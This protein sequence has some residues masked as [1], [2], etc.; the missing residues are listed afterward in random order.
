M[1]SR[2]K[3]TTAP[4]ERA[5][6]GRWRRRSRVAALALGA[7]GALAKPSIDELN[8]RIAG[9]RDQAQALGAQI[10]AH[11]GRARGRPAAGDRRR[12]AR[13]AAHRG[14][15]GRASTR[16]A[17]RG[18]G[19][20]R[21]AGRS[22][23]LASSSAARSTRSPT[24]WWRSTAAG[25]P[26]RP[27]SC[28]TPTASTT[29]RPAPSTCAGSR[30]PTRRS[31]AASAALRDQVSAQARRG[32]RAPR[33]APRPPTTRSRPPATRSPPSAPTPRPRRPQL[34]GLRAQR[35]AAVDSAAVAGRRLDRRGPA[36]RADLR[37]AG[38]GRGQ[39]VARRLGDPRVDRDLRVGRQLRGRQPELRRR[40]RVPDPA[41]DLGTLRRRGPARRTPRPRSRRR[42]RPRSGPTRAPPPGTAPANPRAARASRPRSRSTSTSAASTPPAILIWPAES[43]PDD[44]NDQAA[45][46]LVDR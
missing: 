2:S 45:D 23:A 33:R 42:S 20:P 46:V 26:T 44:A 43:K 10:D 28:S 5:P 16:G 9:A 21:R 18:R 14:A 40:R 19:R 6:A 7:T 35:Q 37:R 1:G 34:A 25:C 41:L 32:R 39:R 31:S 17:A 30:R 4:P 11:L 27:R 12:P 3:D 22:P 13:G 15:R 8:S 24:G 29:S 36:A 38:P